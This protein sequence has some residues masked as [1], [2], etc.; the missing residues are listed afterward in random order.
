MENINRSMKDNGDSE[1]K[2]YDE[3]IHELKM[4]RDQIIHHKKLTQE[5]HRLDAEWWQIQ[6]LER[7]GKLP[8]IELVNADT[9]DTG[10]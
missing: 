4:M 2:S 7:A 10:G 6:R 3:L 1:G 8:I 5:M 9:G